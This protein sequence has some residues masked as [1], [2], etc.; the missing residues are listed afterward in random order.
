MF[1]IN[2]RIQPGT[3]GYW[4]GFLALLLVVM[5]TLRPLQVSAASAEV[6][7]SPASASIGSTFRLSGSGFTSGESVALWTT[8][9]DGSALAAGNILADGNGNFSLEVYSSDPNNLATE[10]NYLA[11]SQTFD[12]DGNANSTTWQLT[13]K[14]RPQVGAW[15]L[16]AQGA[17]SSVSQIFSFN[18]QMPSIVN[19]AAT[20][21]LATMGSSV[22]VTAGGF[23]PNGQVALWTTAPDGTALSAGNLIADS[24]GNFSLSINSAD[25]NGVATEANNLTLQETFDS[26]GNVSSSV[27][28]LILKDQPQTGV[29][30]VTAQDALTG[31]TQVYNFTLKAA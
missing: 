29:W 10:G 19:V 31:I 17:S 4:F 7:A 23:S 25:P 20:P 12:D 5:A 18:I 28:Q 16:T 30:H 2:K 8:A 15:H 1:Q 13:L 9:P 24:K 21:A 22:S 26:D 14:N 11:I 3:K 6:A 27:W